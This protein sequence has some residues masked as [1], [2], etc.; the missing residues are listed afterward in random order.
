M[1]E[2]PKFR[3]VCREEVEV[4]MM[5]ETPSR[6][7]LDEWLEEEGGANAISTLLDQ[8]VVE[9]RDFSIYLEKDEEEAEF[10]TEVKHGKN[11]RSKS[12]R[13]R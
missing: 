8:Q 11:K 2:M 10:N 9:E 1:L 5:V 7:R 3:V 12:K 13:A 4:E 6:E